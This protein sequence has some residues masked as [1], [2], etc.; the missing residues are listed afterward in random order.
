MT[1]LVTAPFTLSAAFS[2]LSQPALAPNNATITQAEFAHDLAVLQIW[3]DDVDADS[4]YSGMPMT[5][6]YGRPGNTRTFWGYVN[7]AS[8][9]NVKKA[10]SSLVTANSTIINCVG[11][12][13]W[14]KQTGN[15]SWANMTAS[16]VVSQ[17]AST[18]G[19]ASMIVPHS[20]VWPSL[21]MAGMSYWAF[22]VSLAQRIGYTFYC[23][24]IQL[25][26]KPRATNP[27]NLAGYVASFD[28]KANPAALPSFIPT[29]GTTSAT[30]GQNKNRQMAAINPRTQSPMSS[31]VP[32]NPAP[33]KLGSAPDSP[34][35]TETMHSTAASQQQSD[36]IALGA[37]LTNQLY[38]TASGIAVGD[39][40]L[41]QGA[42]IYVA[43]AN[44]SQNGLWYLENVVHQFTV[45]TYEVDFVAGRDSRG[46]TTIVSFPPVVN[47]PPQATLVGGKWQAA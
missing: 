14:M 47:S 19:L 36:A 11:A 12:S 45:Q 17:I 41:A 18:F 22:C 33:R 40:L 5:I 7:D 26:F 35:F 30:G 13:W 39:P 2:G 42:L 46:A 8:R 21:Q 3:A 15:Q 24:G 31:Y 43:N 25:V 38:M 9:S 37:G 4:Y 6:S 34:I 29:V 1:T 32:G 27:Q 28:Y 16:Q 10:G 20:T 23:N 44:G